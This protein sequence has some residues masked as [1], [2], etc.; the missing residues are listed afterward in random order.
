M[1]NV[2]RQR[3]TKISVSRIAEPIAASFKM[4][5]KEEGANTST[6]ASPRPSCLTPDSQALADSIMESVKASVS[7]LR[8]GDPPTIYIVP[9][10][11]RQ[12]NEVAYEPKMVSIGPYHHGKERLLGMEENKLLYLHSFLSRNPDHRLEV[13]LEAIE[14]LKDKARSCYSEKVGPLMGN[15][16]VKMMVL[17]ACFIVEIFLRCYPIM[18]KLRLLRQ[19]WEL[20]KH[21]EEDLGLIS[22]MDKFFFHSNGFEDLIRHANG[23]VD[24]IGYD[25]LLLENQIPFHLLQRIFI[26]A[27]PVN[28]PHLLEKMALHFFNRF[29]CSNTEIKINEYSYYHLLHLFHSHLLPTPTNNKEEPN[30]SCIPKIK[31]VLKFKKN[32]KSNTIK[33]VLNKLKNL[34]PCSNKAPL[35]NTKRRQM[36]P[37]ATDL[38]LAGVK[39]KKNEKSNNIKYVLNKKKKKALL[40]ITKREMIPCAVDL[41]LAGDEFKKNEESNSIL[42]V[43]F[44]HGVLEIPLLLIQDYSET[45]FRNLV[46]F[47]QC[48]P[49]ANIHFTTYLMFMDFLVNTSKDAALLHRNGIIDNLLGSDDEVAHLFNRLCIGIFHNFEGSYLSDVK[50]NVQ[51]HCENK[52]NMWRASLKRNYFT[53]PWSVISLLAA[54][55]LLLLTITQ[56][57]Y[58]VFAYYRPRS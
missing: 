20:L 54:S 24:L 56:T 27:C 12:V 10:T 39:F 33:P 26:M 21:N 4:P 38:Q 8:S 16:F 44:S 15:E 1:R 49:E 18:Y 14:E 46:A 53:N 17:D 19:L 31:Y 5:E 50:D 47:E 2:Q 29:M 25:M 28:V 41:Q 9:Q 23:M 55:I 58:T 6:N 7:K 13:Y 35:L 34:L 37:C 30:H 40:P 22:A 48:Y 52:W 57:F 36:M 43:K 45:L 3:R 51:K 32:E 11:I 42:N